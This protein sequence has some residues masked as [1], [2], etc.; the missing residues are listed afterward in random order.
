[1]IFFFAVFNFEKNEN[2]SLYYGNHSH[3]LF[4]NS[5]RFQIGLRIEAVRPFP[6][7]ESWFRENRIR[8]FENFVLLTIH[9]KEKF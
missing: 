1:M 3:G 6:I 9:I 7:E 4:K 2:V 8:S 5:I